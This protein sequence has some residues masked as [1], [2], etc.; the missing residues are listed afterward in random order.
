L[1]VATLWDR[2]LSDEFRLVGQLD[3]EAR[4]KMIVRLLEWT[5]DALPSRQLSGKRRRTVAAA[6]MLVRSAA[7]GS[8]PDTD[9]DEVESLED[10]LE[11]LADDIKVQDLWQLF[12]A[13]SDAVGVSAE[14]FTADFT[15]EIMSACYDVIRDCEDLPE[16]RVG[17]PES[18]V[19]GQERANANCMRAIEVQKELVR[20]ALRQQV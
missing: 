7:A 13:L 9:S 12:I 14:E 17:T 2:E 3:P 6:M 5:I 15:G 11:D 1:S 10:K 19:L 16:F 8:P 4:L 20:E 18:V